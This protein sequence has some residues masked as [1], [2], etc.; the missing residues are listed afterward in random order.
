[1]PPLPEIADALARGLESIERSLR[2][3]QA[4]R[5]LDALGEVALH[6][7]LAEALRGAG[8]GV[9]RERRYPRDRGRRRRSEGLRCDL[10]VTEEGRPIRSAEAQGLLFEDP[11]AVSDEEAVW[12]EVKVIPQH[13]PGGANARYGAELLRPPRADVAKLALDAGMGG[14][15]LLMILFTADRR[16]AE[17]DLAAWGQR[18]L[19]RGLRIEPPCVRHIDILDRIGNRVCTVALFG[20]RRDG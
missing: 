1:M 3:E 19:D 8:L 20:V 12:M 5:G 4:V 13:L 15:A 14:A 7:H 16:T 11:H 6:P 17:H 2:I 18:A 9:D 10:V